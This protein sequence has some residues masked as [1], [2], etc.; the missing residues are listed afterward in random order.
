MS[1]IIAKVN[2]K[3]ITQADMD[4]LL[5]TLGPQRAMQFQSEEGQKQ[6]VD[7]LVNQELFYFDALDTKLEETEMFKAEMEVAKQN[8]LKQLNIKKTLDTVAVTDN[9]MQSFYD[10]NKDKFVRPMT[11]TASHILVDTE[12]KANEI[13]ASIEAGKDFA[14]AA[15]EFSSCPSKDRGG[16]LGPFGQGQMVP[17]F[18]EAAFAME[19]GT[20]STPVKTQFGYHLIKLTDK[21]EEGTSPFDEVKAQIEQQLVIMQQNDAY[22]KKVDELK[23]KY[24]VELL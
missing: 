17:E 4:L 22:F 2:G 15:Q 5:R 9:D 7:E 13:H 6:L 11:V 12:E 18:E 23:S 10:E 21:T 8:I 20:V 14:E 19:V 24:T 1:K 16:D 3:E